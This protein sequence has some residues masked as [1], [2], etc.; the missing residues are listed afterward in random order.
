MKT[1]NIKLTA[2]SIEDI[3]NDVKNASYNPSVWKE[4]VKRFSKY[5]KCQFYITPKDE[6]FSYDR[7]YVCYVADGIYFFSEWSAFSSS[8]TSYPFV[9]AYIIDGV[10]Y[11]QLFKF[12]DGSEGGISKCNKGR[13]FIRKNVSAL[14][15]MVSSCI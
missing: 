7:F 8:L 6:H 3:L 5:P 12:S 2:I 13:E 14:N 1:T 10:V 9:K 11:K 15:I 4:K